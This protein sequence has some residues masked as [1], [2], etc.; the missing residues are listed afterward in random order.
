MKNKSENGLSVVQG[1]RENGVSFGLNARSFSVL[2]QTACRLAL[3]ALSLVQVIERRVVR[4]YRTTCRSKK[5]ETTCRFICQT[6]GRSIP[7]N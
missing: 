1:L 2:E 3:R 6:T 5:E 7:Q 4:M